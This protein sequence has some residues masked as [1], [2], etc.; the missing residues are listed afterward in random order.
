MYRLLRST[1]LGCSAD[2]IKSPDEKFATSFNIRH[3]VQ[4]SL[5]RTDFIIAGITRGTLDYYYCISEDAAPRYAAARYV[6][7]YRF[8]TRV[9]VVCYLE[10][11]L[12]NYSAFDIQLS[13]LEM[14]QLHLTRNC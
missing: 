14:R 9:W 11:L 6:P 10:R 5:A 8:W 3:R 4:R 12:K 1:K 2:K 13:T 7:E